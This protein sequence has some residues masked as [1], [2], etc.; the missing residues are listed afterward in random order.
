MS[1]SIPLFYWSSQVFEKKNRENYGDLLSKYIV[2]Q[3]SGQEARFYNAV[4]G[5][6]KWFQPQ[7]LMAIGSIL[8]YAF[9]NAHVWGSGIIHKEDN[10]QKATFYAVR[11]PLSRKRIL[12][13]GYSC[14]E[15]YGDPALLLP[16][17]YNPT[18]TKEVE[19]G[20]IPHYVDY[21]EVYKD[22]DK[23][24]GI[25]VIDLMTQD[26]EQTTAQILTCKRIVSSS[27]HGVIVAHAYGIPA[28]W[29]QFSG[30][31][32]GDNIKYADYFLSVGIDPYTAE[33]LEIKQ[34]KE[35]F[36]RK[37]NNLPNLPEKEK[38]NAL[39]KGL[40]KSFPDKFLT[41]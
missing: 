21:D 37:V 7:Y 4:G 35:M 15:V 23:Q 12:E 41:E 8:S 32:S 14:P 9:K 3:V 26:V 5:R 33:K 17:F 1:K 27:L 38:I 6:K 36:L 31:L 22:Y 29:V 16:T 2:T 24:E 28:I 20:I 11:G 25:V 30:K 39:K 10:I 18:V 40:V 13:Q 34:T 19:V